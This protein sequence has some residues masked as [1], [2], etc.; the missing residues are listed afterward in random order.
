MRVAMKQDASWLSSEAKQQTE[1]EFELICSKLPSI[2]TQCN[3]F[4]WLGK[5]RWIAS[6][7]LEVVPNNSDLIK[8]LQLLGWTAKNVDRSDGLLFCKDILFANYNYYRD[9]QSILSVEVAGN[10][11]KFGCSNSQARVGKA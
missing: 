2:W 10:D 11:G 1:K 5:S 6:T 4:S 8:T 7:R 9:R 3:K